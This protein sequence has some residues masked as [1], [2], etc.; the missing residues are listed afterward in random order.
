MEPLGPPTC[1]FFIDGSLEEIGSRARVFF[2]ESDGHKLNCSVMCTFK[3][4][5]KVIKYKAFLIGLRLA[6]EI[7]VKRLFVSKDSKLGDE[8]G[9]RQLHHERKKRSGQCQTMMDFLPRFGEKKKSSC[10]S[11]WLKKQMQMRYQNWPTTKI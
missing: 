11:I 3:A 6:F 8:L 5:N 7:R 9:Q 2:Y 10:K 1:L 4:S